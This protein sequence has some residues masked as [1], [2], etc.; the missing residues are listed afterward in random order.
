MEAITPKI[1]VYDQKNL[2]NLLAKLKSG[3]GEIDFTIRLLSLTKTAVLT[4]KYVDN[5]RHEL[6]K[7][8]IRNFTFYCFVKDSLPILDWFAGVYFSSY[9]C[10]NKNYKYHFL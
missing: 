6:N 5:V 10:F 8:G 1:T 9:I 3:D 7:R 4:E 2:K